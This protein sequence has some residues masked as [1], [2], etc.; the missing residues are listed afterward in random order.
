MKRR[1]RADLNAAGVLELPV[2]TAERSATEV[3]DLITLVP[4]G[5]DGAG[6]S[7]VAGGSGGAGGSVGAGGL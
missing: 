7:G 4:V 5:A 1:S 3:G 6:G 2:G